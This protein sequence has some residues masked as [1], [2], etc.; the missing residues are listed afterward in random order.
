MTVTGRIGH[1]HLKGLLHAEEWRQGD[2]IALPVL[3][4]I[5]NKRHS[6][7]ELQNDAYSKSSGFWRRVPELITCL[8]IF[9]WNIGVACP[10]IA[11]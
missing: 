10:K 8:N 6:V 9:R 11:S 4:D 1:P 7:A 5:A 3:F 2:I